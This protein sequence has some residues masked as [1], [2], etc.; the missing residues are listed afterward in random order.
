MNQT[1][2]RISN[3]SQTVGTTSV[4]VSDTQYNAERT[5]LFISNTSTGGQKISISV[6]QEAV[7]GQGVTIGPGGFYQDS[8][9]ENYSP[10]NEQINA[11]SDL[12]GGTISI[13]ERDIMRGI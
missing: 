3:R 2:E 10:T 1:I 12:A 5:V 9:G 13:Q 7:A 11:I 6:G 4:I 8:K